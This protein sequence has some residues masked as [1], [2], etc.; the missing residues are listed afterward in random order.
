M[1]RSDPGYFRSYTF[2]VFD[3]FEKSGTACKQLFFTAAF[4]GGG[5]AIAVAHKRIAER[6]AAASPEHDKA[7]EHAYAA[8]HG[9]RNPRRV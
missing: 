1:K 4:D 2:L 7:S 5:K 8:S 3:A 9:L 6:L